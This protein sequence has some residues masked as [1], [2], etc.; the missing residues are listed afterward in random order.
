[1]AEP[2]AES[3]APKSRLIA[4]YVVLL[5]VTAATAAIVFA[6]GADKRGVESMAGG[7]DVASPNACLGTPPSPPG[8]RPL[9]PSAPPQA[10]I[11]G[12]SFDVKQSGEFVNL[13]NAQK[14]ISG[15]L[16][17]GDEIPG[18]DGARKLTGEVEC[19]DG[20]SRTLDA[21][22]TAGSRA[23]IS[24][25]LGG[26]PITANLRRDPPDAGTPAPRAPGS[27]ASTYKSTPRST[28][29]GGTFEIEKKS[30]SSY[31]VIARGRHLGEVGYDDAKGTVTGDIECTRGGTAK[32]RALAVDRNLNNVRLI[33]LDQATPAPGQQG[34]ARPVMTTASGLTP[35]GENFT[36][37]K[38]RESF[39]HT[40]AAFLIA[41]AIVMLIARLF[42]IASVKL[43]QPRVMGEVV[44]GIAL[45][46][47][48]LGALLPGVQAAVFPTDILPALGVVANLGLVFYMFLVGLELDPAQLR[49]RIGQAAAI[50]NASV[51]L[52]MILGIAVALPI[53]EVVGPDEDFTAFA[54]FMGVAMSITAFPVLARILVER[55]MLKRP[56]G[57]LVLAS[58]A[59]DDVTAWFLI[60][61]AIAVATA[62]GA[63]GVLQTIALAVAFCLFMAV[64]VRP[65]LGR[66]STAYDEAGRVPGG[67]IAAIFAGVLISAYVT[68][69]IGI[70][71]IFGAFIMGMIMPR[72]AGLTEDVTHRIEDFVVIVLLPLFFAYTGL[73]TNIGLLDRPILWL[74]TGVLI[75]VAIVGKLFGAAIAARLTGFDWRASFVIGT[76]MNTRGLTELIVLNLALEKGVISDALFAMLVIMALVTTFMA[77]PLLKLL[78]PDNEYG[79]PVEE[80]LEEARRRSSVEFPNVPQ[81]ERSILVAPQTDTALPQLLAL[82]EPLARSEPPRELILS[83][84][85]RPPRRAQATGGL[86][87][88]NRLLRDASNEV[89][90]AR[91]ELVDRGVASRAIAF[92]SVHPGRDLSRLAKSEE[93]D[94]LLIDGRRPLLGDGVPRGDVGAV[95]NDAECDVAVLVA[96]E[97][98]PVVP[99][100]EA[101]VLVPFGGAEHDWAA[102]E[103][104]AWIAA[105]T[106]APLRLLGAAGQTEEG[107]S[108]TR[109]LADAGLL[110]QQYAGIA[111]APVVADPGREG[112]VA[113]AAGSGLLVVGLSDR[114]RQEG[115][116][117][118]RSEIAKAAPA[119]VVFV[120]RGLRPGALAPRGDVTRF[121]WSSPGTPVI[122]PGQSID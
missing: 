120:R 35:A 86:Q 21:R 73:K 15:K 107:K 19:V 65:M 79:A 1:M 40:V 12:P 13:S 105:A 18:G 28:C 71:V 100:A 7:Y 23:V 45:G 37:T 70:A 11:A 113:A 109:L 98:E 91:L 58:A 88:E 75:A 32:L 64:L 95:L 62:G 96:R 51:A 5:A 27:I 2:T 108:S 48:I 20:S 69:E 49:G 84:L 122:R 44:A 57:A 76:L 39:G 26:A 97:G 87:T 83:R 46:P 41:V 38:Q 118:T 72:N 119:P 54:L 17:L 43:G 30:D 66:V 29:L 31:E 33:P 116:G 103:L 60:A 111:A 50:S 6:T 63:A 115:L 112:I 99:N 90:F 89:N 22:S 4:F 10:Q 94:L 74:I 56:V 3:P 85:V 34:A 102:L 68:E 14:S 36:A 77:G 47:T 80:E 42:G 93:V 78:D 101:A 59:I 110:V 9:P 16:R 61:L 82:A 52:P 106:N 121:G 92:T 55:R 53:Y 81:P 104:G 25:T 24:G 8:G 67:W 117:P 114:W